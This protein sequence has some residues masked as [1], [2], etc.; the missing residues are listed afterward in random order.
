M[1]RGLPLKAGENPTNL[2]YCIL[3]NEK[4]PNPDIYWL[5]ASF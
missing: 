1:T 3:D 4:A 2:R 5:G